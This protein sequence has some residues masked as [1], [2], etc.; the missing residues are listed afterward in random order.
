MIYQLYHEH[1]ARLREQI[2][3]LADDF[4][5]AAVVKMVSRLLEGAGPYTYQALMSPAHLTDIMRELDKATQDLLAAGRS[6]EQLLAE[7]HD[8]LKQRILLEAEIERKE[9]EAILAIRGEGRE[10]HVRVDGEKLYMT[11]DKARDAYKYRAC[12]EERKQLAV[13]EAELAALDVRI[14]QASDIWYALKE[15]SETIRTKAILQAAMLAFLN[16]RPLKR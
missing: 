8:L 10:A 7:K 12:A 11:N 15:A 13:V 3:K 5:Q 9:A 4:G 16:S 2:R 1:D 6:R 14:S